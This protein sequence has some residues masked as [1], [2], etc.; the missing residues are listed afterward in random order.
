M[1][2]NQQQQLPDPEELREGDDLDDNIDEFDSD[3]LVNNP[4]IV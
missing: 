3:F 2:I 1:Y 4:G